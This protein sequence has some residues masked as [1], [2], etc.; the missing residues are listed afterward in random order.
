MSASVDNQPGARDRLRR[1]ARPPR[2]LVMTTS[3]KMLCLLTLGVGFGAVNTG[4][5]LLFLLLG[6]LLA[7]IIASGILSEAVVSRVSARRLI[8]QRVVAGIGARGAYRLTNEK[9]YASLSLEV[10]DRNVIAIAGPAAGRE[11]G[12][13]SVSWWKLW[14]GK[15]D[16]EMIANAYTLRLDR[17]GETDLEA[18]FAIAVRGRYQMET[19]R[20]TTR[21]PF[22]LFEKSRRID[23]LAQLTVLPAGIEAT[24]WIATVRG[25]FGEVATNHRGLGEEFFGLRDYRTGEDRRRI[26]W[27]ATARRGAAVVRET[28]A[29]TQREV[30]IVFCDWSDRPLSPA[31]FERGVSK[32]VG[33]IAAL[34]E[35][36]WRVGFRSRE[37]VIEPSAGPQQADAILTALAVVT[38]HRGAAIFPDAVGIARIAVGADGAVNSIADADVAL[39]FEEDERA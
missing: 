38:Q 32:T 14:R 35:M 1:W 7:L 2:E 19:M 21:F 13:P 11:L 12:P 34:T 17:D 9:A 4:N 39:P 36:G 28:E 3:G 33:L 30:E 31:V 22:G 5:N 29:L 16:G 25:R 27:K 26:H 10:G 24:D 20:I 18:R 6:M 15:P 23:S 37:L 8:P